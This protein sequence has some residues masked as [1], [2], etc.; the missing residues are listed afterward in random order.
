MSE[1]PQVQK[2]HEEQIE[3][4]SRVLGRAF[5]DDPLFAYCIPDPTE[6]KK[7]CAIHCKWLILLGFLTG[8][9]Y[10]SSNDIEGVAIW[11]PY[12]IK[13][14]NVEEQPKELLIKLRKVRKELF[15]DALYLERVTNFEEIA[16]SFQKECVD[17][18]HWY[19]TMVGV[20]SNH[21]GNGYGSKLIEIRLNKFDN[22]NLPCYLH[23]ENEKNIKFYEQFGFE[24]IGKI[25]IPD[26]N[27]VFHPMLR[28]KK[29]E[30]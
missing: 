26:S 25:K 4:A 15:S 11:H 24:L 23:T 10:S 27:V 2:L 17:F 5:Q 6:R 22:N 12:D 13:E 1:L 8:E 28:N 16:N 29:K 19:L 20:D 9:V 21:Q 14:K 18:P 7:K 3:E 30:N